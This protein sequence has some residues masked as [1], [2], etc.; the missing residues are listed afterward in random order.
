MSTLVSRG[1]G[2][3]DILLAFGALL[4]TG[5]FLLL[6]LDGDERY[7]LVFYGIAAPVV[8][9]TPTLLTRGRL[10]FYEPIFLFFLTLLVSTVGRSLYVAF[11]EEPR[12]HFLLFDQTF[13]AVAENGWMVLV[14]L[15]GFAVGYASTTRKFP[16]RSLHRTLG[17]SVTLGRGNL[18]L[19]SALAVAAAVIASLQFVGSGLESSDLSELSVKRTVELRGDDGG[20]VFGANIAI[21]M[22]GSLGE[23]LGY[24]LLILILCGRQKASA[25]M[26]L[27]IGLLYFSASLT[28]FFTSS[29]SSIV[30]LFVNTVLVLLV[31]KKFRLLPALVMIGLSIVLLVG[32]AQ[33]RSLGHSGNVNQEGVVAEIVGSGNF[34]D[35]PRTS[36][37][38]DRVPEQHP[39]L[40]GSSYASLLTAPIPRSLWPGKPNAS[41]G[42]WV[43][44]ELFHYE[45]R[46]NGWPPGFIAEAHL[47]FGFLGILVIPLLLGIFLRCFFNTFRPL[48]TT[49]PVALYLYVAL[50]W[51]LSVGVL[52]LNVAQ[53]IM[54]ALQSLVLAVLVLVLCRLQLGRSRY[55]AGGMVRRS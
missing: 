35:I 43:K 27:L 39:Y 5:W 14:G 8:L 33:L 52:G 51:P 23:Y 28:P 2:G 50:V 16:F 24:L 37:I 1:V 3:R 22:L 29:R 30:L 36:S 12:A 11:S 49:E 26:I 48:L 9:V 21:R 4:L 55:T 41:L 10:Y 44:S 13:P 47:N 38:I 15:F 32:M 7:Y 17:E 54:Q 20:T 19:V 45:V 31:L 34:L 40:L 42:P 18:L 25:G 53:G 46:N 6:L